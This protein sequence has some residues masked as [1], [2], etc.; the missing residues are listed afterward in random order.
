MKLPDYW[1]CALPA[2]DND[3][4]HR[5]LSIDIDIVDKNSYWQILI[6]LPVPNVQRQ[7]KYSSKQSWWEGKWP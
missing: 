6:L 4:T 5:D 1:P 3:P 2:A 7:L